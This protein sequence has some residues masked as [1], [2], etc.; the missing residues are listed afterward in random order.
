MEIIPFT[1]EDDYQDPDK[2]GEVKKEIDTELG[3]VEYEYF[4]KKKL[5]ILY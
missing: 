3:G 5:I 1:S 4:S 2:L